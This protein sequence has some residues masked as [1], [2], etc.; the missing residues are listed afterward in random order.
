MNSNYKVLN[1]LKRGVSAVFSTVTT[2]LIITFITITFFHNKKLAEE[3]HSRDQLY[4]TWVAIS[5]ETD[6]FEKV[7]NQDA[8]ISKTQNDAFESNVAFFYY[9]TGKRLTYIYQPFYLWEPEVLDE[10]GMRNKCLLPTARTKIESLVSTLVRDHNYPTLLSPHKYRNDW[11]NQLL[12]RT[13]LQKI[14]LWILDLVP[15]TP[16]TIA[17]Y[18]VGVRSTETTDSLDFRNFKFFTTSTKS[19]IEFTPSINKYCLN[20]VN[21]PKFYNESLTPIYITEWSLKNGNLNT[22]PKA[23]NILDIYLGSC[24]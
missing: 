2:C 4:S 5:K 7:K 12:T 17:I 15:L 9:L 1:V 24:G 8:M 16:N 20:Q 21:V 11:V 18:F 3:S 6:M 14:N 22:F 23:K 10:C 19:E 13:D